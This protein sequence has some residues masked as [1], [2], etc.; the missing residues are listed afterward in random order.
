M[1]TTGHESETVTVDGLKA[2][3]QE[4]KSTYDTLVTLNSAPTST[5][6]TYTHNGNTYQFKIG[7]EVRVPDAENSEDGTNGYV[8]YKL[9]DIQNG[10]GFHGRDAGARG[11]LLGRADPAQ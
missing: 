8:Y 2:M 4:Y 3:Q 11:P 10:T 1:A 5:T 9:Y 7:D 6:L